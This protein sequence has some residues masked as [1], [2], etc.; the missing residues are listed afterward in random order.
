M[1]RFNN[2]TQAFHALV[3][4]GLWETEV[5][6]SQFNEIDFSQV[7]SLAEEQSVVGL[8]AAGLEHVVD[9]KVPKADVLQFV[10]QALQLEQNNSAM[11]SFINVIIE[12]MKEDGICSL[13]V[14]GQGIAQCYIRHLWRACGDVD[15]LLDENNYSKAKNFLTPLANTVDPEDVYCKHQSMTIQSWVIEIHGNM[16]TELSIRIDKYLSRLL[17]DIFEK[18]RFRVW[19]NE[20]VTVL[21]PEVDVDILFIFTHYL[22]HFYKGGLGLRQICDWCRLLYKYKDS[23][24]IDLLAE[25]LNK[26]GLITEWKVF[27]SYAVEYLGMPVEAMPLYSSDKYWAR[28][29]D[30]VAAFVMKVGNMGHNRD[31]AYY[32]RS[33]LIRKIVSMWRKVSDV[34]NHTL[35]FPLDSV[36]FIFNLL[37]HG[38]RSVLKGM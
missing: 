32:G 35:I 28:K 17:K 36:K 3:R 20:E 10:G 9:V 5:R 27:A 7:L 11:N 14:K 21:L 29:A 26:M 23:I 12:K 6:L 33:Y 24:N 34:F 38:F 18:Q 37:F 4:A 2:N 19:K 25:R 22:K 1:T 15:L 16:K 13:L 31:K 8:I 30:R